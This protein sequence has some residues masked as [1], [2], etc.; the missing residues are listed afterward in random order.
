MGSDSTKELPSLFNHLQLAPA[1]VD[2]IQ[3]RFLVVDDSVA[4]INPPS[5]LSQP[6]NFGKLNPSKFAFNRPRD[7]AIIPLELLHPIFAEF[8]ANVKHHEPTPKDNA[9]ALEMCNVMSEPGENEATQS[10]KFRRILSKHYNI[11]LYPA[12]VSSTKRISDGHAI[13]GDYM[14]VVFEMKVWNGNGDPEI[15]ASLYPLEAFRP[16]IKKKDPLDILPCIIVYCVGTIVG[17]SGTAFTDRFQLESLTSCFPLHTNP[18]NN[19]D[20]TLLARAFGAFKIAVEKLRDHYEK[21]I[22]R[23]IDELQTPEIQLGVTFPYPHSYDT[24]GGTTIEFTYNFRFDAKKLIFV[25][26]TTEGTKVL[27]KF[28]QRYSEEAHRHCAEAGVAPSLLGFQSLPAEWYMVVMGYLN[29]TTYRVLESEDGSNSALRAEIRRVVEVLHNGGFVHG[30]I[31]NVNMVMRHPWGTEEKAQ[32][33]FLL[34]FDWAGRT[35]N[36]KYPPNLNVQSVKRH[37][38]AKDGATITEEHDWAMVNCIFDNA[39]A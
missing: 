17:F 3:K 26:T 5:D 32:N 2:N 6:K 35:G 4:R 21:L 36:T 37:D 31:R 7:H 27:V 25:A 28:T 8:K 24:A 9:L 15:Q 1:P 12:A 11:E 13:V 33:V 30:D 23:N 34:D 16:V 10:E 38:E 19:N 22:S 14:Y 29:P 18:H 20:T 39:F